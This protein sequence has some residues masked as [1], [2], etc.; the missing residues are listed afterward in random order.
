[1]VPNNN[2]KEYYVRPTIKETK[3]QIKRK[4]TDLLLALTPGIQDTT[5]IEG[6]SDI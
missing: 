2:N 5:R 3:K 4:I 6:K 1:M